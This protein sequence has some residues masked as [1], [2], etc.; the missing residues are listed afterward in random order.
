MDQPVLDWI[1]FFVAQKSGDSWMYPYQRTPMGIPYVSPLWWVFVGKLS[2]R[3]PR[4][5]TI[6]TMGTLL[7]LHQIVP[8]NN[9]KGLNLTQPMAKL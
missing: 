7:G 3:I 1:I 8:W 5:N 4:P 9:V 2:P 6:D